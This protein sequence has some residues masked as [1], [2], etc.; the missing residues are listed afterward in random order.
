M[1]PNDFSSFFQSDSRLYKPHSLSEVSDLIGRLAID[2]VIVIAYGKMIPRALLK[3]PRYGWINLHFSLLPQYRGAA[4]VQRAILD[5]QTRTGVTVFQLDEGMDTGP[6]FAHREYEIPH[7][8]TSGE[9]LADL[10]DIGAA[11]VAEALLKI[12]Q[13]QTPEPQGNSGISMAPKITKNE[14]RI[15]WHRSSTEI[16]N[17]IRA[18]NPNPLAWTMLEGRRLT[19]VKAHVIGEKMGEPGEISNKDGSVV[20]GT[21]DNAILIDV[22]TPEGKRTMTGSEWVRGFRLS[23]Q[24][25]L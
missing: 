16:V 11:T 6:L 5:G 25:C 13:G 21:S 3:Q 19:I 15:N 20:I 10:S 24:R 22:L 7:Q 1:K 18:F 14:G 2:L 17:L 8:A 12:S 4:P 9:V 23:G